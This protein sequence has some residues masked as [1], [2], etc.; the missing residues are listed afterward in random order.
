M[1]EINTFDWFQIDQVFTEQGFK[2]VC[3]IATPSV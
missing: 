1:G 3:E 2:G